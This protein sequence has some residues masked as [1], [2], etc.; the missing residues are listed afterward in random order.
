MHSTHARSPASTP[1]KQET[2]K[3]RNKFTREDDEILL[4]MIRERREIAAAE[5]LRE[6]LDGNKIFKDLEA[7]ASFDS[8][9][10]C[11]DMRVHIYYPTNPTLSI[12]II[13]GVLGVIGG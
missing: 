10:T 6:D 8:C 9:T 12:H 3:G 4:R 7:K 5:G 11:V 13:H 2:A 1:K